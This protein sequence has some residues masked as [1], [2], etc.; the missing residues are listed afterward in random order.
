MFLPLLA[1]G[2]V[3][4]CLSHVSENIVVVNDFAVLLL[5]SV[6]LPG[7]D[8]VRAGDG[9][10]QGVIFHRLVEVQGGEGGSIE[11]RLPHGAYENQ[12]QRAFRGFEVIF[13]IVAVLIYHVHP[14]AVWFDVEVLLFKL[15]FL[16]SFFAH[17]HCHFHQPHV[18]QLLLHP[19]LLVGDCPSSASTGPAS[20]PEAIRGSTWAIPGVSVSYDAN[21]NLLTDNLNS[22]TWDKNWGNMLT[23]TA[24]S[25][26]V[27]ATYDALGRMVENNTGGM[28]TEIVYAPT[29]ANVAYVHGTTLVKA[30]I[31][32]PGGAKAVYTS[33]G[34]AYYRHSDWLGSSRLTSTASAPTTA[35]S[36][37]A[38]AP[39]GEQYATSGTADASF[40]GQDSSTVTSLY[41]FQFRES[42]P[43]Q[44]RWIS[45]DPLGRG[46]VT[47]A[48][49]QSW[50]RYAYVVNNP[51]SLVDPLGLVMG[52]PCP[53]YVCTD[54]GSGEMNGVDMYSGIGWLFGG[55]MWWGGLVDE[56]GGSGE[57]GG[58]GRDSPGPPDHLTAAIDCV[59]PNTIRVINYDLQDA[60][61][62]NLNGYSV[63]EHMVYRSNGQ[64]D[65][66]GLS[67]PDGT[68]TQS[69]DPNTGSSGFDDRIG[70]LGFHDDLQTFTASINGQPGVSVYVI[71]NN[72]NAY[73]T[74]GIYISGGAVYVNGD[75]SEQRCN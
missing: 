44:G 15:L 62:N 9:L 61:G 74:N 42:S 41:D 19:I 18:V 21:G 29:G 1:L 10:H 50:N 39:F 67:G 8:A 11:P 34:L 22:Y 30:L 72:N 23:V 5:D 37:L 54:D 17:N 63:T 20:H 69:P 56:G 32:L 57:G 59:L 16:F 27:T 49:P 46:A 47:R 55:S 13:N 2:V 68:N 53:K 35:Y 25:T 26:T 6:D 3:L 64:P 4:Q 65:K 38:Y 33:S 7:R 31:I 58:G 70:G 14:L 52:P 73:G 60:Q 24:G 51:L 12:L 36:S 28:F 71:D 40:T 43:S 66:S 75:I 45:P 48:N